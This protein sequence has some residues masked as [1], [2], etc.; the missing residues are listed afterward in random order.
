[1]P[2]AIL[3]ICLIIAVFI[4]GEAIKNRNDANDIINVTGLGKQDFESDLIVWSASFTNQQ[5]ELKAA[6]ERL[7]QDRERVGAYLISKGM[8]LEEVVFSS[9]DINKEIEYSYDDQ[10]RQH[11]EFR[12]YRLTQ[13]VEIESKEV[14]KI[15]EISREVTELINSGV[16]IYSNAP[17]YYYTQLASLKVEMV[18]AATSDARER[19]E[20]IAENAGTGLGDL[21]NAQM[22]IFQII[23]QNSN[24]DYSWG[25]TYNTTS[26]MKTATITM[27]LQFEVE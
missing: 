11:S 1:M 4:A 13:R 18:A 8:K 21:K 25:G 5:Y 24:E 14:E 20:S 7:K 2:S 16:E 23:A 17:Q 27:R 22:G 26:K 12:G 19:A 6:Y 10:G 9:V 3:G 15:E